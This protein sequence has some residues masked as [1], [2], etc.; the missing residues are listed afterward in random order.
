MDTILDNVD[1]L[2]LSA[3]FLS[4]IATGV[5]FNIMRKE[6]IPSLDT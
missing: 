2:I 1:I 5:V 4:L 3:A 6:E